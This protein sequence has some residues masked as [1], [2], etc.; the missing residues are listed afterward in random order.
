MY[1]CSVEYRCS[2]NYIVH[3]YTRVFLNVFILTSVGRTIVKFAQAGLG[4]G[5]SFFPGGAD[6]WTFGLNMVVFH[7]GTILHPPE[8][9]TSYHL[10]NR[11]T[12]PRN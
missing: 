4:L 5:I 8:N 2:A 9:G 6:Y 11:L 12:R 1:S 3:A 10:T 7:L